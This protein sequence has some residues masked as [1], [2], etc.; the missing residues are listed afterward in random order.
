GV[1]HDGWFGVWSG[2]RFFG[3]IPSEELPS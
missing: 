1:H 2:G 3:I